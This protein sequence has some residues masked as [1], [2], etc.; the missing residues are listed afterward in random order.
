MNTN[1][2]QSK[3]MTNF[4]IDKT[5]NFRMG[6]CY[7]HTNG[8][9]IHVCGEVDSFIMGKTYICEMG[10]SSVNA[11]KTIPR[12][13]FESLDLYEDM[14]GNQHWIEIPKEKFIL[15][16]FYNDEEETRRLKSEIKIF[17][18]MKKIFGIKN[19]IY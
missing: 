12:N 7:E 10:D 6:K 14:R 11:N 8:K 9:Q 19:K 15:M 1:H 4:G 5:M 17:E 13:Y 18:R 2:Q 16:N 3:K